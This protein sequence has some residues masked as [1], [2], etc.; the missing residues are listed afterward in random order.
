VTLKSV[1][2]G[3][4]FGK[5]LEVIGGLNADDRVILNP[6]DS[7]QTVRLG[8]QAGRPKPPSER[9]AGRAMVSQLLTGNSHTAALFLRTGC[10]P[11]RFCETPGGAA[12]TGSWLR[13]TG[14]AAT[15]PVLEKQEWK[16]PQL[17]IL[18]TVVPQAGPVRNPHPGTD[19]Y[20][21]LPIPS[22][23]R[24]LLARAWLQPFA[25]RRAGKFEFP[26]PSPHT[27]L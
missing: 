3:R 25:R 23:R 7:R 19:P 22:V 27:Q 21:I 18:S 12:Q 10:G 14:F 6:S 1:K 5:T 15:A 8:R 13:S 9:P 16:A 26:H 17:P 2:L 4:D 11:R 24:G 20:E